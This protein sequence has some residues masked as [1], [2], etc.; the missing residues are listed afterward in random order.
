MRVTPNKQLQR[1]VIRRRGH[2]ASASATHGPNARSSIQHLRWKTYGPSLGKTSA[3]DTLLGLLLSER[4]VR[5]AHDLFVTNGKTVV[6]RR[7]RERRVMKPRAPQ[8][9]R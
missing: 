1:T 8:R 9:E 5:K 6:S 3:R 7:V 4:A 2:A